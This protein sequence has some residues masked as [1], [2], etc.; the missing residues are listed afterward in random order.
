MAKLAQR[1]RFSSRPVVWEIFPVPTRNFPTRAVAE[2]RCTGCSD[3][4][5]AGLVKLILINKESYVPL[6]ALKIDHS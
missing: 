2:S 5:S 1:S 3:P 6:D 4:W